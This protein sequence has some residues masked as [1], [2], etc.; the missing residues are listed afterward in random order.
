M[1]RKTQ[2]GSNERPAD[3]EKSKRPQSQ[4]EWVTSGEAAICE[5]N[6]KI[7]QA[8]DAIGRLKAANRDGG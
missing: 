3:A 1:E 6:D 4:A 7:K 5:E 8:A 2:D